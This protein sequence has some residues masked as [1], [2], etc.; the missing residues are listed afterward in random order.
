MLVG[1]YIKKLNAYSLLF[2][3]IVSVNAEKL[4]A[5]WDEGL[6]SHYNQLFVDFMQNAIDA[7]QEWVINRNREDKQSCLNWQLMTTIF[8]NSLI[9]IKEI[10]DQPKYKQ[11]CLNYFT[12]L[13]QW[14]DQYKSNR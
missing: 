6:H 12:A 13:Q 9:F 4:Q 3:S 10:M 1:K 2:F 8:S 14:A 7:G 11:I 5:E